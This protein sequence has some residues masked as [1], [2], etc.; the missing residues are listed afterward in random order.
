MDRNVDRLWQHSYLLLVMPICMWTG[1]ENPLLSSEK[2]FILLLVKIKVTIDFRLCL[3]FQ[4]KYLTKQ[5]TISG[6][7]DYGAHNSPLC[8]TKK[9]DRFYIFRVA[10]CV[11]TNNPQSDCSLNHS[12]HLFSIKSQSFP[13][14]S[15]NRVEIILCRSSQ[16]ATI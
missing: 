2:Q 5:S 4:V 15:S 10:Y 11:S 7:I 9:G 1:I 6:Q 13:F 8:Y 12:K 3:A 14:I 16:F